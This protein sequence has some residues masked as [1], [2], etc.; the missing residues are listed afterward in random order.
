MKKNTGLYKPAIKSYQ[1]NSTLLFI[2]VASACDNIS[3]N[4][5]N[6]LLNAKYLKRSCWLGA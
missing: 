6:L 4:L 1:V 3:N 5:D 2:C